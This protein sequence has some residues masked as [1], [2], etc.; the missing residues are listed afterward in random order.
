MWPI[1][2]VYFFWTKTMEIKLKKKKNIL[3]I[4]WENTALGSKFR[5]NFCVGIGP[6]LL[7][8][9][10]EIIL[11]E[12]HKAGYLELWINDLFDDVIVTF[13]YRG[14]YC[15]KLE[16]V[17]EISNNNDIIIDAIENAHYVLKLYVLI[18]PPLGKYRKKNS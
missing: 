6:L 2:L 5:R 12:K 9:V 3:G 1:I 16:K 10:L 15:C 7:G 8:V 11:I 14:F 18:P 17:V 13:M 4:M